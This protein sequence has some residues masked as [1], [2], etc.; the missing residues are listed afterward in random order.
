M[1]CERII[2]IPVPFINEDPMYGKD[3]TFYDDGI[4]SISGYDG[5][6]KLDLTSAKELVTILNEWIAENT[7]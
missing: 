4:I 3:I 5:I 1:S 2:K 6:T 7:V